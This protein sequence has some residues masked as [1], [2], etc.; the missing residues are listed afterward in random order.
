MPTHIGNGEWRYE[1]AEDFIHSLHQPGAFGGSHTRYLNGTCYLLSPL[2]GQ[3]VPSFGIDTSDSRIPRMRMWVSKNADETYFRNERDCDAA[4]VE[5]LN[6]VIP[7]WPCES[8]NPRSAGRVIA[9]EKAKTVYRLT[10]QEAL[11]KAVSVVKTGSGVLGD[12]GGES[13]RAHGLVGIRNDEPDP[14]P[15]PQHRTPSKPSPV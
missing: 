13:G 15:T 2:Y 11:Q 12:G 1:S 4:L 6:L 10:V 9:K 5:Y 14:S 3:Q 8:R 7:A